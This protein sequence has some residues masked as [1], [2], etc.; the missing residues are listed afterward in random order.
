MVAV[1]QEMARDGGVVMEGRDIQTVVLP[2]AEVKVFLTASPEERA[3]R[4]RLELQE[5]GI[6][7]DFDSVLAEIRER[8]R[9]DSNRRHSPLRAAPDADHVDTTGLTLDQ[10]V[11]RVLEIV[12][13][14]RTGRSPESP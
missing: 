12:R 11:G 7:S 14:R 1:Q 13:A 10:V 2:D 3:N 5:R 9:R 4:R 6:A 8:D